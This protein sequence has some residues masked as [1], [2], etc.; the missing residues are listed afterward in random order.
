MAVNLVTAQREKYIVECTLY[1]NIS[2][3]CP[4]YPARRPVMP[5]TWIRPPKRKYLLKHDMH[6]IF[7]LCALCIDRLKHK[8]SILPAQSAQIPGLP[9]PI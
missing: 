1:N 9:T 7:V 8:Q 3:T 5:H 4:Q 2:I 6:Y